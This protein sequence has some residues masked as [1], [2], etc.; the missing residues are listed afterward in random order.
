MFSK[1]PGAEVC[2]QWRVPCQTFPSNLPKL[3][4][5]CG[6]AYSRGVDG[7]FLCG[8]TSK[9]GIS[10]WI[11]S[12]LCEAC[13]AGTSLV[14]QLSLQPADGVERILLFR[15]RGNCFSSVLVTWDWSSTSSLVFLFHLSYYNASRV[16][17]G[18][19]PCC[20]VLWVSLVTNLDRKEENNG[21]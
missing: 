1:C 5:V 11:R 12:T 2:S 10:T 3:S 7:W 14:S 9:S 17:C 18:F 16:F 6:A 21:G 13:L 8:H 4:S 20:S 15:S 19:L